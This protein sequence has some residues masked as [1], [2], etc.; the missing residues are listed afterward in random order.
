MVSLEIPGVKK[1]TAKGRVY[2]Y[3]RASGMTR[4]KA[5]FGTPEFLKEI[6]ALNAGVL[7]V[8]ESQRV[9]TLG[10]LF[11]AY[12]D[13]PH[14]KETLAASTR[15]GYGRALHMLVGAKEEGK[16][17]KKGGLGL[18]DLPLALIE[19]P[20]LGR[21]RRAKI[22]K[23][24]YQIWGRYYANYTMTLLRSIWEWGLEEGHTNYSLGKIR[25]IKRAK[26]A[27]QVNRPWTFAEYSAVMAELQRRKLWGAAAAIDLMLWA[28]MDRIDVLAWPWSGDEGARLDARRHKTG[29][30]LFKPIATPLRRT[31]DQA[32]RSIQLK[33]GTTRMTAGPVHNQEG[34]P[35]TDSGLNATVRWV[36][37]FLVKQ[38]KAKKGLSMKGLHHT[39]GGWLAGNGA[40][41]QELQ[42]FFGHASP[43][44]TMRY[45]RAVDSEKLA[46]SAV[47]KLEDYVTKQ[48]T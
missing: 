9:S 37:A 12:R 18:K 8:N 23:A 15:V 45:L 25:K 24:V 7:L 35:Y 16:N 36:F 38:G 5:P 31:L 42:R 39:V 6:E 4:I 22:R 20:K 14:W 3:H 21:R 17:Q 28:R 29:E 40:T 2:Y 10:D 1:V 27:P 43:H 13:S 44:A 41:Q 32:P 46:G 30:P 26:A 11:D 19:E 47:A 33:D 48:G 34:G